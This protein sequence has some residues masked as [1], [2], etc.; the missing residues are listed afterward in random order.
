MYVCKHGWRVYDS[1]ALP[2]FSGSE[3]QLSALHTGLVWRL[4]W[5]YEVACSRT[6]YVWTVAA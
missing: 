2:C 5:M 3:S 6:L 1:E 4:H